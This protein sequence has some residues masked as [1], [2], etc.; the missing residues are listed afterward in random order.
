MGAPFHSKISLT[1]LY[2]VGLVVR[3]LDS[4]VEHYRN[5]LGI[6]TWG[7]M[8]LDDSVLVE[9]TYRGKP[10][11]HR[12]KVAFGMMGPM[13]IEL[14]QPLE[15]ETIYSDF[16]R[17]HGEGVH[18]L[19]HVRVDNL[20]QAIQTFEQEGFPCIQSGRVAAGGGYAYMDTVKSLGVIT[21][22]L[23]SPDGPPPGYPESTWKAWQK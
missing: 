1:G 14:I 23:E 19:G 6:Q 12:F 7:Y 10:A 15:G 3:D 13:Q 21:E 11:K 9:P 8:L 16:L 5:T 2:Q 20:A 22:L 4:S 18:H 17:E